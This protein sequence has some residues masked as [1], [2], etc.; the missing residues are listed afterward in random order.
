MDRK[1]LQERLDDQKFW[2]HRLGLRIHDFSNAVEADQWI[3]PE[4]GDEELING[5][6]PDLRRA[7]REYVER[8]RLQRPDSKR[9]V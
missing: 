6:P 1:K 5:L 9:K 8:K 3:E 2:L 7:L 4:V